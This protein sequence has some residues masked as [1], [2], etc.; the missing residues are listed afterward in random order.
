M[1]LRDRCAEIAA[2]G[3]WDVL[4]AVK[5]GATTA[6]E[7]DRLVTEFGWTAYRTQLHLRPSATVPTLDAHVKRWLADVEHPK[8]R[9]IY[10][11]WMTRLRDFEAADGRLG[12]RQW[13]E[14]YEHEILDALTAVRADVAHN[15]ARSVLGAW[16]S[17]FSWAIKR[18][19]SECRAEKRAPRMAASPVRRAEAWGRPKITRHRF[20]SLDELRALI[21]ATVPPMRA[22]YATLAFTGI[23]VGEF[24]ALPPEHVQVPHVLSIGPWGDWSPKNDRGVRDIP[25]HATELVPLLEEYAEG[26]AGDRH[27]FINPNTGDGWSYASF[28]SRMRADVRAAG[29]TYGQRVRGVLQP[30]GVTPHTFRH[31]LATWLCQNDVQLTKIA[32]ILGDTVEV[33]AA[34]YAHHLPTDLDRAINSLG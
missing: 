16:G 4:Q 33:V 8:T 31:T 19:R 1:A 29:M 26:W 27:F 14:V 28:A 18:E 22:Q 17:F 13:F 30:D 11:H 9:K 10:A 23:R 24:M 15:T 25:L 12:D 2:R 34:H 3:E 32:A 7:V 6:E 5:D 21:A 20:F